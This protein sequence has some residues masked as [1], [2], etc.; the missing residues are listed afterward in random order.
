[1]GILAFL[2]TRSMVDANLTYLDSLNR[3]I[4]LCYY[5]ALT[6]LSEKSL[7][8]TKPIAATHLGKSE[9][10]SPIMTTYSLKLTIRNIPTS[11]L[12]YN[13]LYNSLLD[14]IK[15]TEVVFLLLS[16]MEKQNKNLIRNR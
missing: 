10:F 11:D 4:V 3:Y 13:S 5:K 12:L 8:S 16:F 7:V 14:S 2:K 15:A 9:G 6:G 1:N